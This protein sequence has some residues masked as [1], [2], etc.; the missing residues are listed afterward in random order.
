MCTLMMGLAP[1]MP[2]LPVT[3]SATSAWPASALLL[4]YAAIVLGFGIILHRENTGSSQ[5]GDKVVEFALFGSGS[6]M[7]ILAIYIFVR[8]DM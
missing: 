5:F 6:F 2:P 1:I 7:F 8:P 3:L 4:L